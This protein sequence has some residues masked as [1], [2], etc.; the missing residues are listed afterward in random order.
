MNGRSECQRDQI[1]LKCIRV[2]KTLLNA[3]TM[4]THYQRNS[5]VFVLTSNILIV[6]K[7]QQFKQRPDQHD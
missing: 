3:Y 6:K 1:L 2:H 4:I 7:V 5:Y